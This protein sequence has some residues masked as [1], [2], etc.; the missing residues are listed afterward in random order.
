M[1]LKD[2]ER[3]GAL[4][5]ARVFWSQ[6]DG[7]LH[8]GAGKI[9]KEECLVRGIPFESAHTSGHAS[10]G[11]LKRLAAVVSPKC[12]IPIHT[13]ERDRFRSLFKNV[14]LIDDGEWVGM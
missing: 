3:V 8:D 9:L 4:I 10:P 13:F 2:L 12:L 7:Y 14:T 6:R 1:V 5:G 11:D